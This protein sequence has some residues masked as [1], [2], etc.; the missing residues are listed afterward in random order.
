MP[1]EEWP[2]VANEYELDPAE[3][4]SENREEG[5][6]SYRAPSALWESLELRASAPDQALPAGEAAGLLAVMGA[7][8]VHGPFSQPHR[9]AAP[10]TGCACRLRP[11]LSVEIRL[12]QLASEMSGCS[13]A[14]CTGAQARVFCA[15]TRRPPPPAPSCTGRWARWRRRAAAAAAASEAWRSGLQRAGRWSR[16]PRT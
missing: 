2:F 13:P 3:K 1:A 5:I 7:L 16:T 4:S 15:A 9:M 8:D 11:P 10:A 14:G 6:W 12:Q